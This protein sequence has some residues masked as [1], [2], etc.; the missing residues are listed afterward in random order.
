MK[1]RKN[2]VSI[3]YRISNFKNYQSFKKRIP[4]IP[5]LNN[6]KNTVYNKWNSE[7]NLCL[8]TFNVLCMQ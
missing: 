6:N 1:Y 7:I 4:K 3:I 8:V 2:I 5:V